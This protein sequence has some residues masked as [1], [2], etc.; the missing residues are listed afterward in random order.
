MLVIETSKI[1]CQSAVEAGLHYSYTHSV[2]AP[3]HV[4]CFIHQYIHFRRDP[5]IHLP[6]LHKNLVKQFVAV[7]ELY[8]KK[9]RSFLKRKEIGQT[10]TTASIS[11][12]TR[13]V[14]SPVLVWK[15]VKMCQAWDPRAQ[16][17]LFQKSSLVSTG[18]INVCP[19]CE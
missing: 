6:S 12:N 15:R 4:A 3:L 11:L 13:Y 19:K 17:S 7:C 16:G 2:H 18:V 1:L 5:D 10:F 14:R 8:L 9:M